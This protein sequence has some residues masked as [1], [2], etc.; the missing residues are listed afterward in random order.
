MTYTKE[1]YATPGM[2]LFI[3]PYRKNAQSPFWVLVLL[4]QLSSSFL[5]AQNCGGEN[6][7][8]CNVWERVPSCAN[9]LVEDFASGK[10]I[11]KEV[12]KQKVDAFIE[13]ALTPLELALDE[14]EKYKRM[15]LDEFGPR[16]SLSGLTN[17]DWEVTNRSQLTRNW[18]ERQKQ[19]LQ[20]LN[21][22]EIIWPGAHD[23]GTGKPA[24][25][26]R[27]EQ[28]ESSKDRGKYIRFRDGQFYVE[29][30][31]GD[32]FTRSS[33]V[34]FRQDAPYLAKVRLQS[35][36]QRD[37]YLA[38]GDNLTP[39]LN[40]LTPDARYS[41]DFEIRQS[42]LEAYNPRFVQI[43]SRRY[44]GHVLVPAPDGSLVLKPIIDQAGFNEESSFL[45]VNGRGGE[46]I[47]FE[48]YK[49]QNR[50]IRQLN[51]QIRA[52]QPGTPNFDQDATWG[53]TGIP[54]M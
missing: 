23:A 21:L 41:L 44:P 10:C 22:R 52:D 29:A 38:A 54:G 15:F 36:R 27:G 46:G 24:P 53:I 31:V 17:G 1:R 40:G 8:P 37:K 45:V 50:F 19:G 28:L 6:Q 18:M 13:T 49:Y 14:Q 16:L 43:E 25:G 2:L 30:G 9:G 20:C 5:T 39:L 34:A 42:P 26:G 48:S 4:L 33:A 12:A 32:D 11:R 51:G 47:S 7:R 35:M 3:S